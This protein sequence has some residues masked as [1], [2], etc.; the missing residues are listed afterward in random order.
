MSKDY[1]S[2]PLDE[3]GAATPHPRRLLSLW[4]IAVAALFIAISA[5]TSFILGLA[6]GQSWSK[7]DATSRRPQPVAGSLMP[8][9]AFI[10]EIPIKEVTFEFPTKYEDTGPEGYGLWN[11]L[12]PVGLGFLRVPYPRRFDMPDSEPIE[13]D[14]EQGEVYSLS[15]TH[16]LHCL[17]VLRDVI[18]KY[19]KRDKS[20][21]AGDGHEYHCLDYIRQAVMCAGDTTMDYADDRVFGQDGKVTRYG[22]TGANSTHQCRDWDAIKAFAEQHKSGNRTGIL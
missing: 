19:E 11:D 20:R 10:P 3:D 8:Q 21:Y 1:T 5:V 18:I 2:I 17:A 4:C 13:D 15:V 22:F 14:P 9:Q 6:V 12:M 16:Q 7:E